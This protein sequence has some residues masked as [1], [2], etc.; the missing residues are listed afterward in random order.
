M[1]RTRR[2]W[3]MSRES[4]DLA[5]LFTMLEHW[6]RAAVLQSDP[7]GYR[8][9]VRRAAAALTGAE[10]PADEPLEVT[11]AKPACKCTASTPHKTCPADLA[12]CDRFYFCRL[13]VGGL[14]LTASIADGAGSDRAAG[15]DA[16]AWS[17]CSQVQRSSRRWRG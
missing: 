13:R 2:R 14:P 1:R 15:C 6:R 16:R 5:G 3:L 4:M 7:E 11:R 8:R 10:I 9:V 12:I 17:G